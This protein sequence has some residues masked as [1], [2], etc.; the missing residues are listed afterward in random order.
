MCEVTSGVGREPTEAEV[1]ERF[2]DLIVKV[3]EVVALD[4]LKRVH[5]WFDSDTATWNDD[6]I[7]QQVSYLHRIVDIPL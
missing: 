1:K 3:P 7:Y 5:D 2:A 4:I 6:Y